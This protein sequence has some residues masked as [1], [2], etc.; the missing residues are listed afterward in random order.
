MDIA[1]KNPSLVHLESLGTTW[2]GR[3]IWAVEISDNVLT[4]ETEPEVLIMGGHHGN[5]LPAVEIPVQFIEFLV[6]NYGKNLTVTRLVD[7]RE[8]WIIPMVNP[9]GYEYSLQGHDWRKNRRPIDLDG[10]GVI[11][12]TG[13]DLNRNYGYRWGEE[14]DRDAASHDPA[15][16][17]YCG[18]AP[19]SENET[20]AVEK[21][22]NSHN[23]TVSM[24]FHTYGQ[25]IYYPWGNAEDAN[26]DKQET[27][28]AMANEMGKLSGYTPMEGRDAYP[29][30]GDSDDWLLAN[31]TSYPFTIEIGT[32]YI[33]PPA[34]LSSMFDEILPA[35]TYAID[36]AAKPE[37]AKLPDWTVM[38]YMSG[39]NSL[40]SQ[41]E[42]DMNKMKAG[43][44]TSTDR[45]NLVALADTEG[46][47]DTHLYH[48]EYADNSSEM[49]VVDG[50]GVIPAD[51]E[52]DM[53]LSSTLSNF[54]N[55]STTAY[56]AQ[57]YMLVLWGHGGDLFTGIGPDKGEWLDMD[58]IRD[59]LRW[60]GVH[61][62]IIGFDACYMGSLEIY[63]SLVPYTDI[64]VSSQVE[65]Q[66]NGWNYTAAVEK[67]TGEP[68]ISEEMLA[69][70]L[71]DS[72]ADYYSNRG[73]VAMSALDT[74]M[75]NRSVMP[76]FEAWAAL[77]ERQLYPEY[78]VISRIRNAS[79]PYY[80]DM[81]DLGTMLLLTNMTSDASKELRDASRY[82]L[83]QSKRPFIR[84]FHSQLYNINGIG[85]YFPEGEADSRYDSLFE[86]RWTG[87]VAEYSRPVPYPIVNYDPE[88]DASDSF[89][90]RITVK[91]SG[92]GFES[93]WS[94]AIN[95]ST[96]LLISY[97]GDN[98]FTASSQE[99]NKENM[100]GGNCTY[101]A[102]IP[103]S[104]EAFVSEV[105]YFIEMESLG[106]EFAFPWNA[107]LPVMADDK[108]DGRFYNIS[109]KYTADIGISSLSLPETGVVNVPFSM[110]ITLKNSGPI[111]VN[112]TLSFEMLFPDNAAGISGD[113]G[114]RV[115]D[116]SA[117][118]AALITF[119]ITPMHPGKISISVFV[120]PQNST[121]DPNMSNNSATASMWIDRD[122]DGDG[123]GD[124]TDS[125]RDGDGYSNDLETSEGTDPNDPAS[126]P[127]DNDNDK[128]PDDLDPD[129]DND[130][131]PDNT[132]AYP[133]NPEAHYNPL[134][135]LSLS[136]TLIVLLVAMS[137]LRHRRLI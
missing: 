32:E 36:M 137:I 50:S 98:P 16:R 96:S 125:D 60:S 23:F 11:D 58:N 85:L 28:S 132:D 68:Q 31:K 133:M 114:S 34:Q 62:N 29:T 70:F 113:S 19:F 97:S 86:S 90:S 18:P 69:S 89:P 66:E 2:E 43:M 119:H 47:G 52:A 103:G 24:S 129:D 39:D 122:M 46:I 105:W 111:S 73:D 35:M 56:P 3:N 26:G 53:S 120:C 109:L 83:E 59:G 44:T 124:S 91:L 74:H 37:R 4:K 17:I 9:D 135:M 93:E 130:G 117:G 61:M 6:N 121:H 57:R 13:V 116:I 76:T 110:N 49:V 30:T 82:L 72:Y 7:T 12:G 14:T 8:I 42:I 10:D 45:M 107:E 1:E 106:K 112:C 100:S 15:S 77:M 136:L 67:I 71:V 25:V 51:G 33:A 101:I 75:F 38:A 22:V 123:I 20:L 87:V 95:A 40:S 88:K 92:S 55:W 128:I 64:I 131:F 118:G 108:N 27:L 78:S 48:L 126:T 63:D 134:P 54:I 115:V 79:V 65:E 127:P 81:L 102:H 104:G 94:P 41:V 84:E 99:W 80:G 21:L 5:E